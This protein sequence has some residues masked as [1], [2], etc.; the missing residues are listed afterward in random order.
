VEKVTV[1][2]RDESFPVNKCQKKAWLGVITWFGSLIHVANT[3]P[4][5]TGC[6]FWLVKALSALKTIIIVM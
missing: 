4:G 1:A 5:R 6:K 2:I 3:A